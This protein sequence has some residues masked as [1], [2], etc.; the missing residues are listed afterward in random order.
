MDVSVYF[1]HESFV[2]SGSLVQTV[3]ILSDDRTKL[4]TFLQTTQSPVPVIGLGIVADPRNSVLPS[5]TT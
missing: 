4:P 1:V 2:D 3:N 5:P